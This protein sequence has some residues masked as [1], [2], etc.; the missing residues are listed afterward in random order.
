VGL[1]SASLVWALLSLQTK[2]P[3]IAYWLAVAGSSY[4]AFHTLVLDAIIWAALF[5]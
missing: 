2:T 3:G 5:K 4:F 1:A